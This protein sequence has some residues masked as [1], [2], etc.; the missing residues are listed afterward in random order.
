MSATVAMIVA[1]VIA[2]ILQTTVLSPSMLGYLVL[3]P[4]GLKHGFLWQLLSFQFLH[5][6]L[7]HLVFNG[8]AIFF[9]GRSVEY[10]LGRTRW[11]A[12][13]FLSGIAGGLVQM[14]F[15]VI[16]PDRFGGP[17]VGASAGASGLIAAFAAIHWNERFTLLLYFIPINMRGRT[18]FWISIGFA[19]LGL[20]FGRGGIAHAAHLGGFLTGFI[21]VRWQEEAFDRIKNL[22]PF[23]SRRRKRELVKVASARLPRWPGPAGG[24][25]TELPSEEFISREVDP[26]LD[27]ISAHGL[28]SLT[29]RERRILEAARNKMAKR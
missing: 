3:T 12:L 21:F 29:E 17:V 10:V 9:F 4:E 20:A 19:V 7:A 24:N 25:S 27:K 1:L 6:G 28:Q 5:A 11:L 15:A 18:L 22:N 16:A 14:L 23:L 2:F 13:Y 8:I 26:I